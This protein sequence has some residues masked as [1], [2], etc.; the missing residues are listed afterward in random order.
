MQE[1]ASQTEVDH[2]HRFPSNHDYHANDQMWLNGLAYQ[3][4][5]LRFCQI[6]QNLNVADATYTHLQNDLAIRGE[7]LVEVKELYKI[8]DS[9]LQHEFKCHKKTEKSLDHER[10]VTRGL[11]SLLNTINIPESSSRLFSCQISSSL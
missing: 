8:A 4:L 11:V 2:S 5:S 6:N 9:S 7:E 3:Q 1:Q 10:C